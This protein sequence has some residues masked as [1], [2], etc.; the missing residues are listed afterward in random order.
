MQITS[1]KDDA[2]TVSVAFEG[3]G[4][5]PSAADLY[6][7]VASGATVTNSVVDAP[8]IIRGMTIPLWNGF[9]S[10]WQWHWKY[11]SIYRTPDYGPD[12]FHLKTNGKQTVNSPDFIVWI[13]DVRVAGSFIARR[14]NGIIEVREGAYG[15]FEKGDEGAVVEFEDSTRVE[16]IQGGFIDSKH[17]RYRGT[18]ESSYY[19]DNSQWQ[20]AEVGNGRGARVSKTG[21]IVTRWPGSLGTDFTDA[22]VRKPIWWPNG[23]ISYIK[24]VIDADSFEVWDDI[25]WEIDTG[26]TLD[27]R[28]RNYTDE[29]NDDV[30]YGYSANWTAKNRL[31][32]QMA[33]SNL[34]SRQPGFLLVAARGGKI[35]NYCQTELSYRQFVGYHNQDHQKVIL[36]DKIIALHDF[37]DR[38][39]A[40]CQG[41][42]YTGVTNNA[43]ELTV[44]ST[45]Q[46]I[47]ELNDP[48]KVADFGI[49]SKGGIF[50]IGKG[51][52]R[53]V[54]NLF[55]VL[56]F[57][58]F[59]YGQDLTVDKDGLKMFQ[60]AIK[61]AVQV[62]VS[63]Y[64]RATGYLLWFRRDN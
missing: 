24:R 20:W 50:R 61:D 25:E 3:L 15:E 60:K 2:G 53:I 49:A 12:G 29:V 16:I 4:G 36:E 40:L 5:T 55:E 46:K 21:K 13:K 45:L 58:G 22:D 44:Q 27:P 26:I 11:Y 57:D 33:I 28:Y 37:P 19:F 42:I 1:G 30:L 62:F 35:I 18:E 48:E 7:T 38:Y 47:F 52:I 23:N 51:V 6:L 54:T 41:S 56:D 32:T 64:S 63:L 43:V 9:D 10:T 59:N 39:S 8:A 31:H 34:I 17:V 14:I